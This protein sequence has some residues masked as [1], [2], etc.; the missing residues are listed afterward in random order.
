MQTQ[1]LLRVA[2]WSILLAAATYTSTDPDLW[3]N[4]RFGLDILRDASIPHVDPYSF[5]ADHAWINHEW[6]S[7]VI[8]AGAFRLGGNP[9]LILLKLATIGGMLLFLN[10]TLRR[11]GVDAAIVRDGATAVAVILTMEQT[12]HIR[13]QLF[14]LVCFA[15]LLWCLMA[16]RRGSH[17]WLLIL[18]PLFAVW[19]NLHGG[20]LVGG[21]VLALWTLGVAVSGDR[22]Q[23]AWCLAIGVASL[24]ATLLTP[25]GLDLWTFLRNTVGFSRADIVEWQPVYVLGWDTLIR[26]SLTFA[27]GMLAVVLVGRTDRRPQQMVALLAL[28]AAS[29]MVTRL[30]AFFA[31]TVLFLVGAGIGRACQRSRAEVA[32]P[33]R[34][35]SHRGM[36]AIALGVTA[37]ALVVIATN[38]THLRV[39]PRF[40]PGPGAVAF[41]NTEPPGARVLVWFD[42]SEYGI[43]HLAPRMRVSIDGRRETVYS[44]SLQDRHMRFYF[45]APGGSALP[46]DLS[47]DYIWIPRTLPVVQRLAD[48]GWR[49]LY[50]DD[51]SVVFGRTVPQR[52][53]V[54][55][56][57]TAAALTRMF[58]G[59]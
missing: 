32:T 47:A 15:A 43:W 38:L 35:G 26:W 54:P 51:Q 19:A 52:S 39:D 55:V 22:R 24:C 36:A 16:A 56:M 57:I 46:R 14:S 23:T 4:V 27:L 33:P 45:D 10:S 48:D 1:R 21:G 30:Q 58:P 7:E 42:W 3:G 34:A 17:R 41:L 29:F 9:G 37:A 11:E 13:P 50:E 44:P 8:T 6:L 12:R 5:T 49:R 18:P 53:N 59:P 20:W 2:L 31:L 28:A 40:T 25:Y